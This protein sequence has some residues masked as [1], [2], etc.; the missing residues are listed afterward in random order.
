MLFSELCEFESGEIYFNHVIDC[1]NVPL[2]W[3]ELKQWR[4]DSKSIRVNLN[5]VNRIDSAGLVLLLHLIEHAKKF[6]CHIM[7]VF[8]PKQLVMLIKLNNVEPLF[9]EHID[10]RKGE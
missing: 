1:D 9:A 3:N 7:F 2:L 8:I 6:N 4:P 10:N 5:R